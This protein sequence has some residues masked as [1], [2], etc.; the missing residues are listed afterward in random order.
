MSAGYGEPGQT[1]V[2]SWETDPSLIVNPLDMPPEQADAIFGPHFMRVMREASAR[3]RE[4]GVNRYC[5]ITP[6]REE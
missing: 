1:Y 3:V 6:G 5:R 4:R 2:P